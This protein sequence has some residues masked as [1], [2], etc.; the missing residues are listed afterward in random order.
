MTFG[1]LIGNLLCDSYSHKTLL[2]QVVF[3]NSREKYYNKD[4]I[5][6]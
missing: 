5:R 3:Q 1:N 4:L 2:K 6:P